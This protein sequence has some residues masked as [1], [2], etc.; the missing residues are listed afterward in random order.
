MIEKK[1]VYPVTLLRGLNVKAK[2]NLMSNDIITIKQLAEK[3]PNK[4]KNLRNISKDKLK[5]LIDIAR[6]IVYV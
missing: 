6:K 2:N 4:L 3:S 1:K 5:S